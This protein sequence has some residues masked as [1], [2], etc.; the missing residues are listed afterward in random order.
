MKFDP[1]NLA[2]SFGI[3]LGA[4]YIIC[5]LSLYLFPALSY[6]FS[7]YLFHG[8]ELSK[9]VKPMVFSEIAGGL[10]LTV[11]ISYAG[12]YLFATV[13]NYLDTEDK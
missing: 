8:V 13:Y 12:A 10:A 9:I 1:K 11:I 7:S 6:K 3:T 4:I 5:A 2:L